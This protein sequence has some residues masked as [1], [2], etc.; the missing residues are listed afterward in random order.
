MESDNA[1]SADTDHGRFAT[2][3]RKLI[4][5][6]AVVAGAAWVAPA[7]ISSL[8]S[9]AW[10]F[11]TSLAS[12]KIPGTKSVLIPQGREVNFTLIGGGGAGGNDQGFNGGV[13]SKIVGTIAPNSTSSYTLTYW[14]A[15]GGQVSNTKPTNPGANASSHG[16]AGGTG[17]HA[18]G[19]GGWG[20]RTE[21]GGGGGGGGASALV[22]DGV[23][24]V[25]PGG[26]GSG[27]G[28]NKAN[29]A[30]G[31]GGTA[32]G[33]NSDLS[34]GV[35]TAG[36]GGNEG[37]AA[38]GASTTA[39]GTGGASHD[40]TPGQNHDGAPGT[41]T[42][43]GLGGYGWEAGN[44]LN[45]RAGGGAGGG[46]GGLYCGGGGGGGGASNPTGG[47]GGGAGSASII[48]NG[49]TATITQAATVGDGLNDP[50]TDP[51][52]AG[53]GAYTDGTGNFALPGGNGQVII[54]LGN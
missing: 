27:G 19:G 20:A 8:G 33:S 7:V 9:S 4:K 44:A 45:R 24:V 3:R 22:G 6:G 34:G 40:P 38:G 53:K 39:A 32:P 35:G 12:T 26:G 11:G 43:G 15:Q 30:G 47:G 5:G 29:T 16:G 1:E 49:G 18:G 50:G 48:T 52:H 10:A 54:T 51:G 42:D 14:V 36:K 31:K 21:A 37:G 23:L 25:A 28:G 41:E 17:Y 13:A 46:G 2:D